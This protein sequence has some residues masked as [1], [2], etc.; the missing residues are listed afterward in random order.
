VNFFIVLFRKENKKLYDITQSF[1]SNPKLE[2]KDILTFLIAPVQRVPRYKLLVDA[3]I[4]LLPENNEV[5]IQQGKKLLQV[6]E[7]VSLLH[8]FFCLFHK[9]FY[10]I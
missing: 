6:L 3:V 4:K 1:N 7:K 5:V 9:L 2:G 8:F 10:N